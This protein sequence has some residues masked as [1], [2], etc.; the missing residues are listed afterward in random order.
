KLYL[1]IEAKK[2]QLHINVLLNCRD[3]NV[4]PKFVRWKNLKS[5]RHHLRSAYH[6]KILK[7]TTQDQHK[8]RQSLKISLSEQVT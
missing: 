1:A 4:T 2:T 8:S 7:E 6:R 3:N 5:K